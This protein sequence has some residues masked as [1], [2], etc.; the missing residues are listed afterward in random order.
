M[1]DFDT[2]L[3]NY[4]YEDLLTLF[5]LELVTS[6]EDAKKKTDDY[7]AA[8]ENEDPNIIQ[9]I[10]SAQK[11]LLETHNVNIK[12]G[13]K[14][15]VK[16]E[17]FHKYLHVESKYRQNNSVVSNQSTIDPKTTEEI[18]AT[19]DET[20]NFTINLSETL[21]NVIKIRMV[22]IIIPFSWYNIYNPK[23]TFQVTVGTDVP[24]QITIPPGNYQL[25]PV[26][27]TPNSLN[28][29]EAINSKLTN[30]TFSYSQL[31]G[32]VTIE[33]S[34]GSSITID[35][36]SGTSL[37]STSTANS[38][39]PDQ[40]TTDNHF[41]TLLGF[42]KISYT[43]LDTKSKESEAYA[44]IV[45][46]KSI[47]ID[48][49]DF[50]N[51]YVGNKFIYAINSENIPSLPSYYTPLVQQNPDVPITSI[52]GTCI[53]D[54]TKNNGIVDNN[55]QVP[56]YNPS[57]PR[58][59]TQNQIYSLNQILQTRANNV[60]IKQEFSAV[61]NFFGIFAIDFDDYQFG[62]M[63]LEYNDTPDLNER[64]YYGPVDIDR[65]QLRIL[66][67]NGKQLDLNGAEWSITFMIEHLYQY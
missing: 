48:L 17:T 19:N 57:F 3:E 46:T 28:I 1:S 38:I 65:I 11:K 18:T 52:N 39:I 23:N 27:S 37:A 12:K 67:E 40:I 30:I 22:K 44:N 34:T 43:I 31:T 64:V 62:S 4:N 61:P 63:I 47:I 32:K 66:D 5:D 42:K 50:N 45:R 51:N 2:N 10:K 54:I 53:D 25:V 36:I 8:L 26:G 24:V 6:T 14:N 29:I 21:K 49:N 60:F 55:V 41:G 16:R 33:N 7:L 58:K 9:F 56:L 20:G 13:N 59:M 15:P 35:F